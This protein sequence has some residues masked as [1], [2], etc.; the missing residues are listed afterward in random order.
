MWSREILRYVG[1]AIAIECRVAN[2][3]DAIEGELSVHANFELPAV[4]LEVPGPYSTVSREAQVDAGVRQE[5]LRRLGRCVLRE[6][7]PRADHRKANI[8][9]DADR[10]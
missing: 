2:L 5:V 1:K 10:D 6:I 3:E 8:G 4:A 7:G 9:T